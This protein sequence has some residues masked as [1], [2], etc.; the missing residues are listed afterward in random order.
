[1]IA[2]Y[3]YALWLFLDSM[4]AGARLLVLVIRLSEK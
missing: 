3:A 1:M 2:L 4:I